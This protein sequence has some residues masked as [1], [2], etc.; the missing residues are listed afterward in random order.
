MK[1]P[2]VGK[3]RRAWYRFLDNAEPAVIVFVFTLA[4]LAIVWKMWVTR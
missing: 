2:R 4:V 3:V 1:A